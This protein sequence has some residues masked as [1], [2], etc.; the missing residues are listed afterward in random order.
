MPALTLSPRIRVLHA[1]M[2]RL[3][4]VD[5]PLRCNIPD[6]KLR[7]ARN[8]YTTREERPCLAIAFVSD[9]PVE[10]ATSLNSDEQMRALAFDIIVDMQIETEASAESQAAIGVAMA[11]YDPSGL[12]AL[13]VVIDQAMLALRETSMDPLRDTTDLGRY[14]DWIQ[15]VSID[16]DEELPDD[17]GRLVGRANVIYR[18]HSWDPTLLLMRE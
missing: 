2:A 1:V 6:L 16:D 14:S 4:E 5:M 3:I 7:W 9:A 18:V 8:R 10:N 15:D 17:D 11:G 12:L 13:S